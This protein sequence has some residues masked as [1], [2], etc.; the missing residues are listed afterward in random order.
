[1]QEFVRLKN[2]QFL[3]Q[4]VWHFALYEGLLRL[5]FSLS[6]A[7]HTKLTEVFHQMTYKLVVYHFQLKK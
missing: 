7:I 5:A 4:K 3:S 2:I 1:M 6:K